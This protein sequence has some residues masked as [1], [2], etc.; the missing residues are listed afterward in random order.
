MNEIFMFYYKHIR[1]YRSELRPSASGKNINEGYE[2]RSYARLFTWKTKLTSLK[3]K[4]VMIFKKTFNS[5]DKIN[6]EF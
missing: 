6:A 1:Y 5:K 3:V 4:I 2:L